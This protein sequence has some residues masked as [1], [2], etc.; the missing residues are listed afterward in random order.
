MTAANLRLQSKQTQLKAETDRLLA[1]RET[2]LED[3]NNPLLADI[4]RNKET[5]K[6]QGRMILANTETIKQQ[7]ADIREL[8]ASVAPKLADIK[9]ADEKLSLV[10]LET[11]QLTRDNQELT[12]QKTTLEVDVSTKLEELR[13]LEAKLPPLLA[14]I[15]QK[16]AK[17]DE[18]DG[19]Y[20]EELEKKQKQVQLLRAESLELAQS[21]DIARKNEVTTRENLAAF[22]RTLDAKEQNIRIREQKVEMGEDKLVQNSNLLN[23]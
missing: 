19:L 13:G 17:V 3:E 12:E 21:M 1:E 2:A 16:Q 10:K 18:L 15:E 5:L 6:T 4:E 7:K 20:K 8:Q 11:N 9:A 14:D 22:K 23:L